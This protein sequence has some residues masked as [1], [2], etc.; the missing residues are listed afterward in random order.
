MDKTSRQEHLA[1]LEVQLAVCACYMTRRREIVFQ[2]ACNG[3]DSTRDLALLAQFETLQELLRGE[4]RR[5]LE[6]S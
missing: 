1:G 2:L 6:I 4:R 5:L 3:H